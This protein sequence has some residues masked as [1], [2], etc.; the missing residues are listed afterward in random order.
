M[1]EKEQ[2]LKE[3]KRL[4]WEGRKLV[5]SKK[6]TDEARQLF[7]K[8]ETLA[9][10]NSFA[11]EAKIAR[12]SILELDKKYSAAELM[13]EQA[14]QDPS[15]SL[16]A[17]A[18]HIEGSIAYEN[19]NYDR[20][21]QCYQKALDSP[22]FDTPGYAW[23]NMGNAY[24]EKKDFDQAIQ[25]YQKALDSPGYDTPGYA[26][27]NMGNAYADKKDYDQAIQCYQKALES[28]GYDTPGY[29]WFCMGIALESIGKREE[30]I[31]AWEEAAEKLKAAGEL[32]WALLAESKARSAR[33][34]KELR[35]KIQESILKEIGPAITDK[36]KEEE[37]S[38]EARILQ[39]IENAQA[40]CYQSYEKK[41][42]AS[43]LECVLATLWGW[44]SATP[45]VG[46]AT[47]EGIR[48]GGY[49]LKWKG[50][51]VV[52]DPGFDFIRNFHEEGFSAEEIDLVI[53]T[54]HHTDH[55]FDLKALEDL[56]YELGLRKP[57][58]AQR[59][60]W[61]HHLLLDEDTYD[62]MYKAGEGTGY[63]VYFLQRFD[64]HK[65]SLDPKECR[66]FRGLTPKPLPFCIHYFHTNHTNEVRNSVGLR[67]GC[68]ESLDEEEPALVVGYSSDTEFFPELCHPDHLGGCDILNS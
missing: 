5:F 16:S 36:E 7:A 18:W 49:F 6:K 21:I 25:F 27:F 19:K 41:Q 32:N 57:D 14:L 34:P 20:A 33:Q 24:F 45:L 23:F 65:K 58:A 15:I 37:P 64:L 47:L 55:Y 61:R 52:I 12:A 48:G 54:H 13:L 17:L 22:G 38:I 63:Q 56:R 51:G 9:K 66:D 60:Q 29:A 31:N 8:A 50:K 4:F 3:F 11:A 26:W 42:P 43:G 2:A 28:P 59:E 35:S 44:S 30:A 39:K 10:K 62:E 46:D 68:F 40:D 1:T 67:I 53:V